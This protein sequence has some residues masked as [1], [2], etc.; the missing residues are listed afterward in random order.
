MER[1]GGS[2]KMYG[3][4]AS[5][6]YKLVFLVFFI[7]AHSF[8]MVFI[9]LLTG[10][11]LEYAY[12]G[13]IFGFEFKITYI[14]GFLF[15]YI[16][17]TIIIYLISFNM[18]NKLIL[19]HRHLLEQ[20]IIDTFSFK[21]YNSSEILNLFSY[22]V[23]IICEKYL[24]N[25]FQLLRSL[26]FIICAFI[27]AYYYSP[28][29]FLLVLCLFSISITIQLI[30]V[31]KIVRSREE[32]QSSKINFN[33][34][35]L[36][37]ANS[38]FSI[39][40]FNGEK[41]VL[42]K[43][44]ENIDKKSCA[45]YKLNNYINTSNYLITMVPTVSSV[46]A[47]IICAFLLIMNKLSYSNAIAMIFIIG[48]L[49]WELAKLL[50]Y[51]NQMDSTKPVRDNLYKIINSNQ[52]KTMDEVKLLDNK[53]LLDNV[54]VE[55][56]EKLALKNVSLDFE[57]GK[58][59]LILGESGSGKSTIVKLL[60]KDIDSYIGNIFFSGV[61]IKKIRNKQLY[62]DV[63]YLK[64]GGE[65]IH[66]S[67]GRNIS[68]SFDYDPKKVRRSLELARYADFDNAD[69]EK[70]I[71]LEKVNFSG[72][73]LQRIALARLFYHEK[74]IYLLDEFTSALHKELAREIE[75]Q[76]LSLPDKTVII[77][78]HRTFKEDII[79]YDKIIILK[80]GEVIFN[81]RHD[82]NNDLINLYTV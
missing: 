77:V 20:K 70:L 38:S 55:Y 52:Q 82:E 79:L 62:K 16:F 35:V 7:I 37:Y 74:R 23:N 51:K 66:D 68:L 2:C 45:E 22:D 27:M 44:T 60:L 13:T 28:Y 53:I 46:F 41:H 25:W 69:F 61:N 49:M 21:T 54:T 58:K 19:N 17:I 15:T 32:Y 8:L 78:S 75:Q 5:N 39:K 48:F 47:A 24:K 56:E 6:K 29:L 64:Q 36:S 63:G 11:I 72:G 81:G 59:Y 34:N 57:F 71:D 10:F 67:L 26:F 14:A 73:E 65:F 9:S 18:I 12:N 76:V 42:Q 4:I 80:N 43:S 30:F 1:A 31:K 33:K 3:F 50:N 40:F